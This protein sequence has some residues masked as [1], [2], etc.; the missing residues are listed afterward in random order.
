M[1][2]FMAIV[3]CAFVG[4][5]TAKAAVDARKIQPDQFDQLVALL[6]EEMASGGRYE[7][8]TERERDEVR[9]AL[10]TMA[11][12]LDGVD[13][14]EQLDEDTRVAVMNAQ[15]RANAI[16]TRRDSDRLVC[17]RRRSIGT[18]RRETHCETYG[19]R[20]ARIQ[21]THKIAKRWL[22]IPCASATAGEGG[23]AAGSGI[24]GPN[25]RFDPSAFRN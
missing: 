4:A 1:R 9:R 19:E 11:R 12:H 7:Y 8:A 2:T 24:C 20:M 22:E 21:G 3:L 5:A 23:G 10:A 16:L 17:D 6:E 14:I 13:S 18:H 25:I 15:E